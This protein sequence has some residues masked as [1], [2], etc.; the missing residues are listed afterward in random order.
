MADIGCMRCRRLEARIESLEK[1]LRGKRD[2]ERDRAREPEIRGRVK[3]RQ[4]QRNAALAE[5]AVNFRKQWS[6]PEL[7]LASREDLTI[8]EI[9]AKLGRTYDGV[10]KMQQKLLGADWRI[11]QLRD[12]PEPPTATS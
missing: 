3:R 7:E 5:R 12:G 2:R 1:Q 8:A 10:R 4:A 6:G 9:A 11:R